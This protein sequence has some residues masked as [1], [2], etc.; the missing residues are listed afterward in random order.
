MPQWTAQLVFGLG[1]LAFHTIRAVFGRHHRGRTIVDIR[2][3]LLE[4]SLLAFVT[5]GVIVIPLVYLFS[6]WLA[7]ADYSLPSWTIWPGAVIIAAADGLFWRAHIDLGRNWS[8]TLEIGDDQTLVTSGLYRYIRHPMY[9]AT[10]LFT[11]GQVVLLPN[12]IAGPSALVTFL[13]LYLLRLPREE[14]MMIDRFD[15]GYEAYMKRTGRI[16]PRLLG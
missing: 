12:W 1:F 2:F 8:P 16:F 15:E 10:F 3:D 5:L 13:P 7:F 4:K 11:I 6:P 14:R 9:A